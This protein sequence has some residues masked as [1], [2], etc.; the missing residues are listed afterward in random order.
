MEAGAPGSRSPVA[1]LGHRWYLDPPPGMCSGR[2]CWEG[3][4]ILHG[5]QSHN[6]VLGEGSTVYVQHN[7]GLRGEAAPSLGSCAEGK[8]PPLL[9]SVASAGSQ[10]PKQGQ[11]LLTSNFSLSF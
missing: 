1:P 11:V 2:C 9:I 10:K 4:L 5:K 3:Q 7:T 8:Q 6:P